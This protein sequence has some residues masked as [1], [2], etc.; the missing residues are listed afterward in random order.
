MGA[1][2]FGSCLGDTDADRDVDLADLAVMLSQFGT[3]GPDLNGDLDQDG[4]VDLA[5]LAVLL[6]RV[7]QLCP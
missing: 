4:D 5:D 6:S 3:S 7:G 1:A 2:E